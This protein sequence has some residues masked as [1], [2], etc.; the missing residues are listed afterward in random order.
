MISGL[1]GR[2]DIHIGADITTDKTVS[3]DWNGIKLIDTPGLFTDRKDHDEITY[4]AIRQSDL[5]VFS[6]TYMLFDSITAENFKK[7]AYELGYRWKIML[8]VNK[9]ADGAGEEEELMTHYRNSLAKAIEPYSL[10]DFPVCFI[11]A[12]DYCDGVDDKDDFLMEVSRFQT[13]I[14]EL[15]AFSRQRGSLAKFDTPVRITLSYVD[16]TQLSLIRDSNKDS[17]FFELLNRLSRKV[18]QERDRLRTKVRGIALRLSAAIA[19][20]GT[21]LASAVGIKDIEALGKQ[22]ENNVEKLCEKAGEEMEEAVKSAVVSLQEEIKDVFASDLAQAFIARLELNKKE[23]VHDN[24]RASAHNVNAGVDF[25]QLRQQVDCLKQLGEKLI[26]SLVKAAI[27]PGANQ[28]QG[29]FLR[30]GNAAGSE[31]HKSI[32]GIGK[33]LGFKF[34]PY[35]AVNLAK[36]IGNVAKVLGP[37]VAIAA[38]AGDICTKEQEEKQDKAISDAR[39]EITSQFIA[40]GKDLESQIEIQLREVEARVYGETEKKIAEERQKEED[41]IATSNIW[42][43]QLAEIRKNFDLTLQYITK[44]TEDTEV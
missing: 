5:L 32:Y 29:A 19:N 2:R 41:V 21:I 43:K 39:C 23:F 34:Q 27:K 26:Q 37:I 4:E 20:E 16:D 1:T 7:L 38:L 40:M 33:F 18:R 6:L 24:E 11:D 31:L 14:D 28:A 3:Y 8:V 17:V 44:L 9:M 25:E 22:A 13:F 42:V 10:D 36:G 30:A 15:N 35:G 12:K